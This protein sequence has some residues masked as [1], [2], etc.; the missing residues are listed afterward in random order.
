MLSPLTRSRPGSPSLCSAPHQRQEGILPLF[1]EQG[2]FYFPPSCQLAAGSLP[3]AAGLVLLQPAPDATDSPVPESGTGSSTSLRAGSLR[4][5]RLPA[6]A[7]AAAV[8]RQERR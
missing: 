5:P 1:V 2:E 3:T 4:E 6:K 7:S 8:P